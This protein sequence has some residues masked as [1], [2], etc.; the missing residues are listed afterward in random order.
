VSTV[1]STDA[2]SVEVPLSRLVTDYRIYASNFLQITTKDGELVPFVWNP[3][4]EKLAAA[5]QWQE[6]RGLPIRVVILK[7]R[8]VGIST[9][10]QGFNF[11]RTH[12]RPNRSAITLAHVADSALKLFDMQRVFYDHLAELPEGHPLRVQKRHLTRKQITFAN[13][14]SS[15]QVLTVGTGSGRGFTALHLHLS[16][17]AFWEEK[18]KTLLAVKNAVPRR[19]DSSVF[20]ES[21]ANGAGD[22]FHQ[23][24]LRAKR[25]RSG[26]I[27]LFIAWF[28]D[29]QCQAPPWFT[30]AELEPEERAL[31]A[32]HGLTLRQIAWRRLT[33]EDEC[34]GDLNL[35]KQ[36]YPATDTEAFLASGRPVF[37]P[38][39]ALK[40]QTDA[41]PDLDP[42]EG[43][44]CS[45]IEPGEERT[46]PVIVPTR[47]GRL[48]I[49]RPPIERHTYISAWDPSE[50]DPGSTASPGAVLDRTDLSF[51]AVWYGRT[52]PDLL[53]EHACRLTQ[54]YNEGMLAW[55]ANNHGMAFGYRVRELEYPNVYMRTVSAETVAQKI[56]EK[57]GYQNTERARQ[58]LFNTGRRYIREAWRNGWQP[59][60]H[61]QVVS[62]LTTLVYDGDKAVAQEGSLH[63]TLIAAFLALFV[64][65]GNMDSPLEPLP[66]ETMNQLWMEWAPRMRM[67]MK[68]TDADLQPLHCTA[69]EL[70][71]YDEK[72]YQYARARERRGVRSM[73]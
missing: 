33:I 6:E 16:E 19:K 60:R 9:W 29:P 32:A 35:F 24:Y 3:P 12:L 41:V 15:T 21:T 8:R 69:K 22:Q 54:H 26:Y 47:H 36:E 57:A 30:E 11:W 68:P 55:E 56:S 61:P 45:E 25:K 72:M 67:G 40:Y 1:D 4:Q 44:E 14:R 58:D 10:V 64:H 62:E 46:K 17:M 31:V 52:P 50:G 23:V 59:I 38:P 18:K 65:R 49:L 28:D 53:A 73:N 2:P 20:I 34:D 66:V 5:V 48:C 70:E 27:A 37:E 43:L 63:D 42:W 51:S 13:T 39:E 71:D 7:A